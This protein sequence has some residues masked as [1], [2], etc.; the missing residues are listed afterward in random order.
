M[1]GAGDVYV[2]CSHAGSLL[3]CACLLNF[4]AALQFV[5]LK[6]YVQY[7]AEKTEEGAQGSRA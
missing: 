3:S 4:I 7:C 1:D 5:T 6:M 2:Q